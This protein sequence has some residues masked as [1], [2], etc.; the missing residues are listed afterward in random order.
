MRD[1][2]CCGTINLTLICLGAI[3][4]LLGLFNIFL[5][6]ICLLK[7]TLKKIKKLEIEELGLNTSE[8]AKAARALARNA[9]ALARNAETLASDAN[10]IHVT[11]INSLPQETN[12]N[13]AP[14]KVSPKNKSHFFSKKLSK[15]FTYLPRASVKKLLPTP[16]TSLNKKVKQNSFSELEQSTKNAELA[17][18]LMNQ[19]QLN[20]DAHDEFDDYSSQ[21]INAS[22][23]EVSEIIVMQL[24]KEQFAL[25]VNRIPDI[26]KQKYFQLFIGQ[27]E[28][29]PRLNK[30]HMLISIKKNN[31][32]FFAKFSNLNKFINSK[33]GYISV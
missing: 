1:I 5:Y 14:V 17:Q 31:P 10:D 33:L 26:E 12:L 6:F 24:L 8:L 9:E 22:Q 13:D 4:N 18:Q 25:I 21:L 16:V 7:N 28:L 20:I 30:E 23:D 15:M 11:S 27:F 29:F 19:E 32:D 3:T 2:A